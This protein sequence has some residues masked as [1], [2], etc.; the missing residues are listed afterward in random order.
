M[1]GSVLLSLRILQSLISGFFSS[2]GGILHCSGSRSVLLSLSEHIR[3]HRSISLD[4]LQDILGGLLLF[5][6]A[7][8][9]GISLCLFLVRFSQIYICIDQLPLRFVGGSLSGVLGLLG[10]FQ[11]LG[12]GILGGFQ[13]FQLS[14]RLILFSPGGSQ[15]GVLFLHRLLRLGPLGLGGGQ[16]GLRR[17]QRPLGLVQRGSRVAA[18]GLGVQGGLCRVQRGLGGLVSG[19]GL[20]LL[21]C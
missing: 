15:G 10:L 3:R 19:I 21:F 4:L 7:L 1:V 5:H 9:G 14:L 12:G 8:Q 6:C 13:L 20:F 11:G 2:L 16:G 18:L 17:I